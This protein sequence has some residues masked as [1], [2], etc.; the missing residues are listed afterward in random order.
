MICIYISIAFFII[1]I[2]VVGLQ[3]IAT[4]KRLGASIM[5]LDIKEDARRAGDSLGAKIVGFDVPAELAV[6][7]GGYAKSLPDK[8]LDKERKAIEPHLRE[9]DVIILSALVPGEV[10]PILITEK[11]TRN[12][13]PGSVVIDVSIDQGGNCAIT[14]PGRDCV[15]HRVHLCGLWNIPG[16][17]SVHASWLY[18]HNVLHFVENFFKKGIDKP[19]F[20]DEIVQHSLVAHHGEIVHQGMLVFSAEEPGLGQELWKTDGTASGTTL[21]ADLTPGS[22]G[23]YFD[24]FTPYSNLLY[25]EK[26]GQIWVTDLAESAPLTYG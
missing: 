3:A 11:M 5:A 20:Q 18:A 19:D 15:K 21:V 8:W 24:W 23:C 7:E 17:M 13:K 26:D 2:G 22:D 14:E 1:G 10:A 25:F 4:A 6:G 12:M 16:A 9:A